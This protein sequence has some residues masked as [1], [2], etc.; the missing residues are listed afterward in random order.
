MFRLASL[1]LAAS[2]TA[3]ASTTL[4]CA[5]FGSHPSETREEATAVCLATVPAEAVP[6][7]DKIADCMEE[8]GWVYTGSASPRD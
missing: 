7:A 1:L 3:L 8:R 6:Y 4:G 2:V 5:A